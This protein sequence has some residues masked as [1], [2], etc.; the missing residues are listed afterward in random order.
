MILIKLIRKNERLKEK[1]VQKTKR[2]SLT[3]S[4]VFFPST[5]IVS[6]VTPGLKFQTM[7]TKK[8]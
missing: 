6:G 5:S 1:I 3:S 7:I 8:A 2:A 4:R